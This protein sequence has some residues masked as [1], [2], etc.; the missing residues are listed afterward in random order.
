MTPAEF[1]AW[2]EA[3]GWTQAEA[4]EELG[5]PQQRVSEMARGAAPVRRQTL[6]LMEA[7]DRL[8]RRK[9]ER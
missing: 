2:Y 1:R 6:K 9:R 7:L 5:L 8:S 4:A 3:R